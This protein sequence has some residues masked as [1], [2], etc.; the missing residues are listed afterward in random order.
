MAALVGHF[1]QRGGEIAVFV[2]VADDGFGG[3]A[4]IVVDQAD[5]ELGAQIIGQ[6]LRLRKKGF[7]GRL[8]DRFGGRALVAGSR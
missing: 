4:R 3:I 6:G 8:F 7:K 1:I 5:T 2:Q